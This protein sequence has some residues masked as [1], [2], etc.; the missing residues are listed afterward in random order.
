MK[1][2]TRNVYFKPSERNPERHAS[3]SWLNHSKSPYQ[4]SC[5]GMGAGSAGPCFESQARQADLDENLII[6]L[7]RCKRCGRLHAKQGSCRQLGGP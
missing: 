6:R 3:P 5:R 7:R 4:Y 1:Q 2:K